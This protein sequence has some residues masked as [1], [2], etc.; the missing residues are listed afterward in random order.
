MKE[1]T[2]DEL[3]FVIGSFHNYKSHTLMDGQYN[4]LEYFLELVSKDLL[5]VVEESRS[6]GKVLGRKILTLYFDSK[7]RFLESYD[8]FRPFLYV[9]LCIRS[10]QRL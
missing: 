8:N 6:F 10:F 3:K 1:V 5:L 4:S 2:M 9:M 7:E